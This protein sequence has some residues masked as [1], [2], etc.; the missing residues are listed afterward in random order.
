MGISSL[1]IEDQGVDS[2]PEI[3]LNGKPVRAKIKQVD[4]KLSISLPVKIELNPGDCL[5]LS[6]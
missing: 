3:I 6:F 5:S 2:L 4:K 1:D